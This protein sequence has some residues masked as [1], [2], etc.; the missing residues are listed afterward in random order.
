MCLEKTFLKL[1]RTLFNI[2]LSR[3]DNGIRRFR[4]LTSQHNFDLIEWQHCPS[5]FYFFDSVLLV[6]GSPHT[7]VLKTRPAPPLTGALSLY[8]FYDHF[9]YTMVGKRHFIR[10]CCTAVY[11]AAL[12]SFFIALKTSYC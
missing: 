12:P 7:R 8:H 11:F 3:Q 5:C 9:P 10:L 4:I 2:S 1:F 6:G